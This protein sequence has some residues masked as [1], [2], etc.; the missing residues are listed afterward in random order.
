MKI[1]IYVSLS[2]NISAKSHLGYSEMCIIL[3]TRA[4]AGYF[5][6]PMADQHPRLKTGI[7]GLIDICDDCLVSQG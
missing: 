4:P 6:Y 3:K 7:P 5:W 1:E 2:H